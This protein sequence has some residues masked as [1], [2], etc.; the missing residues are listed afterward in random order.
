MKMPL[1][2]SNGNLPVLRFDDT[3]EQ[4]G[5]KTSPELGASAEIDEDVKETKDKAVG[6]CHASEQS[7]DP[8][9]CG[10]SNEGSRRLSLPADLDHDPVIDCSGEVPSNGSKYRHAGPDTSSSA[11]VSRTQQPPLQAPQSN[12]YP[13][14]HG[15]LLI[16]RERPLGSG[17]LR[18]QLNLCRHTCDIGPCRATFRRPSDLRRHQDDVHRL[19]QKMYRCDTCGYAK[20]RRCDKVKEHCEKLKHRGFSVAA[21]AMDITAGGVAVLNPTPLIS[22]PKPRSKAAMGRET[23]RNKSSAGKGV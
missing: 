3:E 8:S 12:L 20:R 18:R 11:T 6:N 13:A 14:E 1:A 23:C 9:L 7:T 15:K 5:C 21:E 10:A 16:F 22:Q 4:K 17:L 19:G 2:D